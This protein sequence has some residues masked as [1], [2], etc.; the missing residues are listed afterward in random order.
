MYYIGIDL[1]GTNIAAGIVDE[2][3][4]LI[5]KKSIPT[6][7][8]RGEDAIIA[9]MAALTKEIIEENGYSLDDVISV[10][11]GSPGAVDTKAGVVVSASN[12]KFKN[13][14]I[15]EKFKQHINKEVHVE[16]DANCAAWGEAMAGA[17]KGT[18]N[19][20]MIT[21]GTGVGGGIILNGEIYSGFNSFAGELGHMVIAADGKMC[22]C[23]KRGCWE[24]YSSATALIKLTEQY[25]NE[26]KDSLMWE[27]YAEKGRFSG[28]TAFEAARMGDK[29]AKK[30]TDEYLRYLSVGLTNLM[31]IFQPEVIVIGGGISNEGKDLFE[32]L[33]TMAVSISYSEEAKEK[34]TRIERAV[35][36][37]DA[38]I[39]GAAMLR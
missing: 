19:S 2:N 31:E 32:P 30:V 22:P 28:K 29:T 33:K 8:E 18:E 4:K 17:S 26:D 25:A 15:L 38:G 12:L 39:V 1:G 23:G 7:S 35:L 24:A 27:K 36:G 3:G 16:N 5:A 20:I 21:L 14:P 37:N 10:G 6:C 34:Y 11:I 9:D 13:T